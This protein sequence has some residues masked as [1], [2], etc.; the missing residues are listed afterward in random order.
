MYV[1]TKA[2]ETSG[3][4]ALVGYLEKE[5]SM[6]RQFVDYL[7]KESRMGAQGYFFDS[8]RSDIDSEVVVKSIDSNCRKL[9]YS[10]TRFYSITLNPS[11]WELQ[12]IEAQAIERTRQVL[13]AMPGYDVLDSVRGQVL[14]DEIMK[15]VLQEYAKKVMDEYALNFGREGIESGS[16]LVWFGRV[17]KDRYWKNSYYS[18]RHNEKILRQIGKAEKEGDTD[19]VAG[20]KR[21]LYY[22]STFR[23]DGKPEPVRE[24]MPKSGLNH[25]IHIIVSRRDRQQRYKLSP[26][27]KARSNDSHLIVGR[28][29]KVGFNRDHF[30][31]RCE[32]TFDE[33]VGYRRHFHEMYQSR[34]LLERD[35]EQFQLQKK[36]FYKEFYKEENEARRQEWLRRLRNERS[37][38]GS[39]HSR[40][41]LYPIHRISYEA[42]L[43][44]IERQMKPYR[45]IASGIMAGIRLSKAHELGRK[46]AMEGMYRAMSAYA[47]AA[48]MNTIT[49]A[50][51]PH[52]ALGRV[53]KGGISMVRNDR[54]G[55]ER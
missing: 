33:L 49:A 22:E 53:I 38:A 50:V 35:P 37:A 51:A 34:K 44:Q 31:Q 32:N 20:L 39:E 2:G 7:D 46:Q 12:A 21:N 5:D 26:E 8:N 41:M 54:E 45:D 30:N 36:E 25:H 28:K 18:V 23:K 16:D 4:R 15:E 14:K 19:K 27:A 55:A 3:C 9:S 48:G 10:E 29:C 1:T 11:K 40:Y 6:S 43:K 24:W 47:T 13:D 52:M 17:E 42:G